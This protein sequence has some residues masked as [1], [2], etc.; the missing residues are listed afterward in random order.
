M[1][2]ESYGQCRARKSVSTFE[3]PPPTSTVHPVCQTLARGTI[4]HRVY[5]PASHGATA[6]GYRYDGPF[7]RMDHHLVSGDDRGILYAALS[8]AGS[9]VEVTDGPL[10]HIGTRR[11]VVLR[12]TDD[13]T[14]LDLRKNGALAAGTD[15]KIGKCAHDESQPWAC[16]FYDE[17]SVYGAVAG[18]QWFNSHNDDEAL[19]FFERAGDVFSVE[20]DVTLKSELGEIARLIGPMGKTIDFSS[21]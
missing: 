21:I 3:P 10:L 6:T 12:L 2:I 11:H 7:A 13:L 14:V 8:Y 4:I 16:Y 15:A 18:L 9:L 5:D 19:A 17:P 20:T 1:S